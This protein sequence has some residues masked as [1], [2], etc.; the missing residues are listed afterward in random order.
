MP[1]ASF[2]LAVELPIDAQAF[3]EAFTLERVNAELGPFVRMTTPAGWARR[4]IIEWPAGRQLFSSWILL[5]GLLPIDRHRFS[6]Q[7]ILPGEGFLEDSSS[8]TNRHWRH[9]RRVTP[10]DGGCRVTDRVEFE[11]RLPLLGALLR[12]VYHGVFRWRHRRLASAYR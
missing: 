3:L 4:P 5:F 6:L 12:P 7:A 8:L 11:C 9:E 10:I 1:T 2:S